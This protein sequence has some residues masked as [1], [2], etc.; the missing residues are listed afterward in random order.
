MLL[1]LMRQNYVI[2]GIIMLLFGLVAGCQDNAPSEDELLAAGLLTGDAY[3]PQ[4]TVFK[5]IKECVGNITDPV[6][7]QQE[8]ASLGNDVPI[9]RESF[10]TGTLNGKENP[11]LLYLEFDHPVYFN[12]ARQAKIQLTNAQWTNA[13][14]A[15]KLIKPVKINEK[16]EFSSVI[17]NIDMP[18]AYQHFILGLLHGES[19]GDSVTVVVPADFVYR[20][21]DSGYIAYN[22]VTIKLSFIEDR[23]PPTATFEFTDGMEYLNN[24]KY[25]G[26]DYEQYGEIEFDVV[27]SE[28]V[29]IGAEVSSDAADFDENSFSSFFRNK[30]RKRTGSYIKKNSD[31]Y[32]ASTINNARELEDGV[33]KLTFK[34]KNTND[35]EGGSDGYIAIADGSLPTHGGDYGFQLKKNTLCDEA[36]NCV[37]SLAKQLIVDSKPPKIKAVT[38]SLGAGA[39]AKLNAGSVLMVG[40]WFDEE[41]VKPTGMRLKFA[42]G[43]GAEGLGDK[44]RY[45]TVT[46]AA[47]DDGDEECKQSDADNDFWQYSYT[48]SSGDGTN[49]AGYIYDN[50]DVAACDAVDDDSGVE[51]CNAADDNSAVAAQWSSDINNMLQLV[52]GE[53]ESFAGEQPQ[54][55]EVVDAYGNVMQVAEDIVITH[56]YIPTDNNLYFTKRPT[57]DVDIAVFNSKKIDAIAPR[58]DFPINGDAI[59]L[60]YVSTVMSGSQS[61]A[62][63]D[64]RVIGV[65]AQAEKNTLR[66]GEFISIAVPFTE[67]LSIKRDASGQPILA[68]WSDPSAWGITD[69]V[70]SGRSGVGEP[71]QEYVLDYTADLT[72]QVI[73]G[74]RGDEDIDVTGEILFVEYPGIEQD[75]TADRKYLVYSKEISETVFGEGLMRTS[76]VVK[77]IR[78]FAQVTDMH[79]NTIVGVDGKELAADNLLQID[80]PR[81]EL[82]LVTSPFK[83][84]TVALYRYDE[85]EDTDNHNHKYLRKVTDASASKIEYMGLTATSPYTYFVGIHF[86]DEVAQSTDVGSWQPYQEFARLSPLRLRVGVNGDDNGKVFT[87]VPSRDGGG[88]ANRYTIK[89]GI[90]DDELVRNPADGNV[91]NWVFYRIDITNDLRG[92]Q[93]DDGLEILTA[94]IG[95]DGAGD[96]QIF[97]ADNIPLVGAFDT[98]SNEHY[99]LRFAV[100]DTIAPVCNTIYLTDDGGG[101]QKIAKDGESNSIPRNK[102]LYGTS[103]QNSAHREIY[104]IFSC[105]KQLK[106]I[107]NDAATDLFGIPLKYGPNQRLVSYFQYKKLI[108]DNDDNSMIV[109]Q[110]KFQQNSVAAQIGD[111]SGDFSLGKDQDQ[112]PLRYKYDVETNSIQVTTDSIFKDAAF[113]DAAVASAVFNDLS[114]TAYNPTTDAATEQ[115]VQF[116][117]VD[118]EFNTF[119]IDSR[120]HPVRLDW[121]TDSGV[122]NTTDRNKIYLKVYFGSEDK[123]AENVTYRHIHKITDFDTSSQVT[124]KLDLT[125]TDADNEFVFD[126]FINKHGDSID[127]AH[128]SAAV[129]IRFV[130]NITADASRGLKKIDSL[131]ASV[132]NTM[133]RGLYATG[134]FIKFDGSTVDVSSELDYKINDK[135]INEVSEDVD[136]VSIDSFVP[137]VILPDLT[138]DRNQQL[139]IEVYSRRYK[140]EGRSNIKLQYR[141]NDNAKIN[142]DI[143]FSE[144]VFKLNFNQQVNKFNTDDESNELDAYLG[145]NIKLYFHITTDEDNAMQQTARYLPILEYKEMFDK[146]G[147]NNRLAYSN[148]SL[149]FIYNF[150]TRGQI[151]VGIDF[152]GIEIKNESGG[153]F[154][155][156]KDINRNKWDY[157]SLQSNIDFAYKVNMVRGVIVES[158]DITPDI[159]NDVV[160]YDTPTDIVVKL[161]KRLF[162]GEDVTAEIAIKLVMN[163]AED[164]SLDLRQDTY[165]ILVR[166]SL[167]AG[168]EPTN[169]IS[170]NADADGSSELLFRF[171]LDQEVDDDRL[172]DADGGITIAPDLYIC[173]NNNEQVR[174]SAENCTAYVSSN[175]ESADESLKRNDLYFKT[176]KDLDNDPNTAKTKQ[177]ENFD[178]LDAKLDDFNYTYGAN[179]RLHRVVAVN[180]DNLDDSIRLYYKDAATDKLT[181]ADTNSAHV[182]RKNAQVYLGAKFNLSRSVN[183][184]LTANKFDAASL[185]NSNI[186]FKVVLYDPADEDAI[187][188]KPLLFDFYKVS[189][190][191]DFAVA[192][193]PGDNAQWLLFNA[194]LDGGYFAT[195]VTGDK[196]IKV[197]FT[198]NIQYSN[199]SELYAFSTIYH[200]SINAGLLKVNTVSQEESITVVTARSQPLLGYSIDSRPYVLSVENI[201]DYTNDVISKRDT[202]KFKLVFSEP[203]MWVGDATSDTTVHAKLTITKRNDSS[204]SAVKDIT[205]AVTA[206]ASDATANN[207]IQIEFN[208]WSQSQLLIDTQADD[209]E[210]NLEFSNIVYST[211][212]RL[213]S[214]DTSAIVAPNL[215]DIRYNEKL[216]IYTKKIELDKEN[217]KYGVVPVAG[218]TCVE[219][220]VIYYNNRFCIEISFKGGAGNERFQ[221]N[222]GNNVESAGIRI[223][224]KK[225]NSSQLAVDD[226]LFGMSIDASLVTNIPSDTIVFTV[227]TAQFN[228]GL[229]NINPYNGESIPPASFTLIDSS[230]KIDGYGTLTSYLGDLDNGDTTADF[231]A[232][233]QIDSRPQVDNNDISILP[234]TKWLPATNITITLPLHQSSSDGYSLYQSGDAEYAN[235]Y[236]E[237]YLLNTSEQIEHSSNTIKLPLKEISGDSLVFSGV[238]P[239]GIANGRYYL[240]I[241]EHIR[242][243]DE[244]GSNIINDDNYI[245]NYKSFESYISPAIEIDTSKREFNEVELSYA[246]AIDDVWGNSVIHEIKPSN[247][248]LILRNGSYLVFDF[249]TNIG[250]FS[251]N[252]SIQIADQ[253][254]YTGLSI[255]ALINGVERN[256]D[257]KVLLNDNATTTLNTSNNSTDATVLR[258]YYQLTAADYSTDASGNPITTIELQQNSFITDHSHDA[259]TYDDENHIV[260]SSVL[261]YS[262][263]YN[264]VNNSGELTNK[265]VIDT[266]PYI[267]A[268]CF[269]NNTDI[270]FANNTDDRQSAQHLIAKDNSHDLSLLVAFSGN[271]GY[272]DVTG[273]V[274]VDF[275]FIDGDNNSSPLRYADNEII[276]GTY[277]LSFLNSD[278]SNNRLRLDVIQL[279]AGIDTRTNIN[280]LKLSNFVF[281][282]AA[283]TSIVSNETGQNNT[284]LDFSDQVAAMK[285]GTV[286][287]VYTKELQLAAANP[288]V[289]KYSNCN[290]NGSLAAIDENVNMY[291]K[292]LVLGITFALNANTSITG[293]NDDDDSL[294]ATISVSGDGVQGTPITLAYHSLTAVGSFVN[295]RIYLQSEQL[296]N[297]HANYSYNSNNYLKL[298]I[299][300]PENFI[301]TVF[302]NID[303]NNDTTTTKNLPLI[304][305]LT[306]AELPD[307][308]IDTRML[309]TDITVDDGLIYTAT[310]TIAVHYVFSQILSNWSS[311]ANAVVARFHIYDPSEPTIVIA[312]ITADITTDIEYQD[313]YALKSSINI[314]DISGDSM[315]YN[316]LNAGG[317]ALKLVDIT[318]D[319]S[320]SA[321]DYTSVNGNFYNFDAAV[322][323]VKQGLKIQKVAT[324]ITSITVKF[325][326]ENSSEISDFIHETQVLTAGDTLIFELDTNT[327]THDSNGLKQNTNLKYKFLLAGTEKTTDAAE[328]VSSSNNNNN[329]DKVRFAYR[330]ASGDYANISVNESLAF[331]HVELNA[332]ADMFD[333]GVLL[334]ADGD[335][336]VALS[337]QGAASIVAFNTREDADNPFIRINTAVKFS[338]ISMRSVGALQANGR[339]TD[340]LY[341]PGYSHQLCLADSQSSRNTLQISL[342]LPAGYNFK[343][344]SEPSTVTNDNSTKL[345]I[346]LSPD[347]GGGIVTKELILYNYN[348]GSKTLDFSADLSDLSDDKEYKYAVKL[349]AVTNLGGD[350]GIVV[351]GSGGN[352]NN[353]EFLDQIFLNY[354]QGI[355]SGYTVT[356]DKVSP[357]SITVLSSN[358]DENHIAVYNVK[359][360][361][362]TDDSKYYQLTE[363]VVNDGSLYETITLTVVDDGFNADANPSNFK[364]LGALAALYTIDSATPMLTNSKKL[365]IHI[366][367]KLNIDDLTA[368]NNNTIQIAALDNVFE[369]TACSA[370]VLNSIMPFNV[371]YGDLS[372][373][374]AEEDQSQFA[375]I[376]QENADGGYKDVGLFNH[377]IVLQINT[378]AGLNEQWNKIQ[379]SNTQD[380]LNNFLDTANLLLDGLIPTVTQK[381]A[382]QL[383]YKL[384]GNVTPHS[385]DRASDT[386]KGFSFVQPN[387]TE[388]KFLLQG[389][390]EDIIIKNVKIDSIHDG[391]RYIF[392]DFIDVIKNVTVDLITSSSARLNFNKIFEPSGASVTKYEVEYTDSHNNVNTLTTSHI[393]AGRSVHLTGLSANE[394]YSVKIQYTLTDASGDT[395]SGYSRSS[396]FITPAALDDALFNPVGYVY[397]NIHGSRSIDIATLNT[398]VFSIYKTFNSARNKVTG[399]V[400]TD[401][402]YVPG[403]KSATIAANSIQSITFDEASAVNKQYFIHSDNP[404]QII[405]YRYR[406][407]PKSSYMFVNIL[408][409]I[410]HSADELVYVNPRPDQDIYESE[411]SVLSSEEWILKMK[412]IAGDSTLT[413]KSIPLDRGPNVIKFA[414]HNLPV[415]FKALHLKI[416]SETAQPPPR[417]L[418]SLYYTYQTGQ[419]VSIELQ[420]PAARNRKFA[421]PTHTRGV[422]ITASST[423]AFQLYNNINNTIKWYRN[424]NANNATAILGNWPTPYG[425]LAAAAGDNGTGFNNGSD[426]ILT[427]QIEDVSP[428]SQYAAFAA[429][430][431]RFDEFV[432]NSFDIYPATVSVDKYAYGYIIPNTFSTLYASGLDATKTKIVLYNSAMDAVLDTIT[433]TALANPSG[434]DGSEVSTSAASARIKPYFLPNG[435]VYYVI[436][437]NP[438]ALWANIYNSNL[439]SDEYNQRYTVNLIGSNTISNTNSL[440]RITSP[441]PEV[442]NDY[443]YGVVRADAAYKKISWNYKDIVAPPALITH[444]AVFVESTNTGEHSSDQWISQRKVLV[445]AIQP[446]ADVADNSMEFN[447]AD[448]NNRTCKVLSYYSSRESADDSPTDSAETVN[449]FDYIQ[450]KNNYNNASCATGIIPPQPADT[451]SIFSIT[452]FGLSS[453]I[454]NI[455]NIRAN[456]IDSKEFYTTYSNQITTQTSMNFTY[457]N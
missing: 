457:E 150:N 29:W 254:I 27:L 191:A 84:D 395:P 357:A 62:A 417:I 450:F 442:T 107:T 443:E 64:N 455:A 202:L 167:N 262:Y 65:Y 216:R 336:T 116:G 56:G 363:A 106:S 152:N 261:A 73:S 310:D 293:I 40:V 449:S 296:K 387:I 229:S 179:S 44:P 34:L 247:N 142:P 304:F 305:D 215:T 227:A 290:D 343:I 140:T 213:K 180:S 9:A 240:K 273:D 444:Y 382:T 332:Y 275:A 173:S 454:S 393:A 436:A 365:I 324:N 281:S 141:H 428:S 312:D 66:S 154:Y 369:N 59:K 366:S 239:Q 14:A 162:I 58:L 265:T 431:Y 100:I 102:R 316:T 87:I 217:I 250:S 201:S 131:G 225:P 39:T 37:D 80:V 126:S 409:D 354:G 278:I 308:T 33:R 101:G 184:D 145:K 67:K 266:R 181:L 128:E 4:P 349:K 411:L 329:F 346:D 46:G 231:P 337:T 2:Y 89:K 157:S 24:D 77:H 259:F 187:T 335:V 384:S 86:T 342:T 151:G 445:A 57:V 211:D 11:L 164:L 370:T 113:N 264:H 348:V 282:A 285:T 451:G 21:T 360:N 276:T 15:T 5:V 192:D 376:E 397:P 168:S 391:F 401:N 193:N 334:A 439:N 32:R 260:F 317:Y 110:H 196:S 228:V 172:D 13:G 283:A 53:Q 338:N 271:I 1:R 103:L 50:S 135:Y 23:S 25:I 76:F 30:P 405:G 83:I 88:S 36:G 149:Y 114:F 10:N 326:R 144:L 117:A 258:F 339:T 95:V 125:N 359:N 42:I 294:N 432:D 400:I 8:C 238:P 94:T 396:R 287:S 20:K 314:S 176:Y 49:K 203:I 244:D 235:Y 353:A 120:A 420:Q 352:A 223:T 325:K 6:D 35:A 71:L 422:K 138:S 448:T 371:K 159:T 68:N 75:V 143:T 163:I 112:N 48:V 74:S 22:S 104:L 453:Q 300:E 7:P 60:N 367:P 38:A 226:F 392:K 377:K 177:L 433:T 426:F 99:V 105:D 18:Q 204:Y 234:T 146:S 441:I 175:D 52:P 16:G 437:D 139:P 108:T 398:T 257:S 47:C 17:D 97:T 277:K 358:R 189:K 389:E 404:L 109:Y 165:A 93:D 350:A 246:N 368:A 416:D 207:A 356:T 54:F 286:H 51:T 435:G 90:N 169:D 236:L 345:V 55:A 385:S 269:S 98:G 3:S 31:L 256:V 12:E 156:I 323:I 182:F 174:H 351:N 230:I 446:V 199:A 26:V 341:P 219:K 429:N 200:K 355:L 212:A 183:P 190:V 186:Q 362:L 133:P 242:R 127:D 414:E 421:S 434:A 188:E 380:V 198:D 374:V 407:V 311:I 137:K 136:K 251:A 289:W 19:D 403:F 408:P 232:T 298:S 386:A 418:A 241:E 197:D 82:K 115:Y 415:N 210:T 132:L 378:A 214:A 158:I 243:E 70:I 284:T 390:T 160:R 119:V 381:S 307:V 347:S 69:L 194:T 205:F 121:S 130:Y 430:G 331:T 81:S 96:N 320:G 361:N 402:D 222:Y 313:N 373:A 111:V 344:G 399:S 306:I 406:T 280:V 124:I 161:N 328:F 413:N 45:L 252:D 61:T 41:V 148:Q 456:V 255:T 28:N 327:N 253:E 220:R 79:G 63:G 270:C 178:T 122:Y 383:T 248:R 318:I 299:S 92:Y 218:N 292:C 315:N 379:Y 195:P 410:K 322:A 209:Y 424:N 91:N 249:R 438:I 388:L 129:G 297:A 394:Q 166:S 268:I 263:T 452:V 170:N 267:K 301:Q 274:T 85:Q 206:L 427:T 425:N 72:A 302:Y 147:D 419:T 43:N 440:F 155:D 288:Y 224:A 364:L 118:R 319:S 321:A 295:D 423:P 372:L 233:L 279:P 291:D 303:N 237:A 340:Y 412:I 134:E 375:I 245:I 185:N 447:V 171:R 221:Y 309:L 330:I 272:S 153:I 208:H 333:N 123:I 78:N